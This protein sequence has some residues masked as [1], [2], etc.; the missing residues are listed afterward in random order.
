MK[1]LETLSAEGWYA[2]YRTH[3]QNGRPVVVRVVAWALCDPEDGQ[4]PF[5]VGLAPAGPAATGIV[6][7]IEHPDFLGYWDALASPEAS[8]EAVLDLVARNGPSDD[9]GG[10]GPA[11][12]GP[13]APGDGARHFR[14]KPVPQP[15]RDA[16]G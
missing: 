15:F 7:V 1:I 14:V 10:P 16:F 13:D 5:L 3:V 12:A 4:L 2:L 6:P 9:D 8:I 11:P